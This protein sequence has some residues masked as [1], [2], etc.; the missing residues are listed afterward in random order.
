MITWTG[1]HEQL[2]T[3]VLYRRVMPWWSRHRPADD[4]Q[5]GLGHVLPLDATGELTEFF[6]G[7][8]Q[9]PHAAW[10]KIPALQDG[11][12]DG[13]DWISMRRQPAGVVC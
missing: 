3:R 7:I 2:V 9:V 11:E 8:M 4:E 13:C 1:T 10:G 5:L 6:E 12:R